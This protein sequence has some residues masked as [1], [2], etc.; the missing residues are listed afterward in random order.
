MTIPLISIIICC[1]NRAHLLPQTIESVFAQTYRPVEII[2][3]D[4]GSM[5]HTKDLITSYGN[6]VRYYRQENQ[7]VAISRN[8]ACALAEGEFIAFQDDDDLMPADRITRLYDALCRF[9]SAV[10]AV[11]DWAEIDGSGKLTGR[12]SR[13]KA[14]ENKEDMILIEDGYKAVLWPHLT[15]TPHTTLFRRAHGEKIGWFDTRYSHAC[16]DTDFF[17]RL[18]KLGP[19]VY[20][21]EVVSLYRR[22]HQSQSSNSPL[23]AYSRLQL[24]EKHLLSM[25]PEQTV[26]KKRVQWRM[27]NTLKQLAKHK[28]SGWKPD[29]PVLPGDLENKTALLGLKH[30]LAYTWFSRIKLPFQKLIDGRT[31]AK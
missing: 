19:F 12:R 2:V 11:G 28:S 18:G 6:K 29:I 31:Q 16:E 1:Y 9:P 24:F 8:N 21:P 14:H 30:Y 22:E 26:L 4:D 17:A 23:L 7:G 25:G 3:F 15:P 20:V 5:D 13:L 10:L 27:L